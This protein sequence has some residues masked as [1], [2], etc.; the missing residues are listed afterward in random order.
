MSKQVEDNK[1]MQEDLKKREAELKREMEEKRQVRCTLCGN[2]ANA[3]GV[4][5]VSTKRDV[6]RVLA[7][8]LKCIT[9]FS[10]PLA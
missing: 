8:A 4:C 7:S 2:L 1:E 10:G 6:E 5:L 9:T 3:L